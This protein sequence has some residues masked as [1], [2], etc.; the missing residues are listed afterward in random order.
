MMKTLNVKIADVA[1]C[2]QS[3]SASD[4]FPEVQ[5]AVERKVKNLL[6]KVCRKAKVPDIYLSVVV[7]VLLAVSPNQKWP[8]SV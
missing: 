3:L 4:I 8:A 7:P 1:S 5:D 6:I 2:L